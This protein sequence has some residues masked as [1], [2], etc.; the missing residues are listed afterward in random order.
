MVNEKQIKD[1]KCVSDMNGC[2]YYTIDDGI[3]RYRT[4]PFYYCLSDCDLPVIIDCNTGWFY[5][6]DEGNKIMY[7]VLEN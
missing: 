6:V 3:T 5:A 1:V 7:E 2:L 4:S